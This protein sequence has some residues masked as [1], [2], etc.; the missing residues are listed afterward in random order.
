MPSNAQTVRESA[1]RNTTRSTAPTR[2]T[3]TEAIAVPPVAVARAYGINVSAAIVVTAP[4]TPANADA[5]S[6]APSP[7]RASGSR[8][9]YSGRSIAAPEVT[10]TVIAMAARRGPDRGTARNRMELL[11][12]RERDVAEG[13]SN[14][15]IAEGLHLS[16]SSIKETVSSALTRL[17]LTNRIQLAI[18]A[19]EA[20]RT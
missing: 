4:P 14:A 19:H 12:E 1:I 5:S 8:V 18:V 9:K 10:R 3:A 17:D 13:L 15:E 16:R 2:A 11:T 7:R 6:P 20:G